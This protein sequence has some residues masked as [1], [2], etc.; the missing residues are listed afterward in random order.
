MRCENNH[1]TVNP[2]APRRDSFLMR[3]WV[4]SSSSEQDP[5]NIRCF[6]QPVSTGSGR[7]FSTLE[8]TI[9]YIRKHLTKA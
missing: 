8:E 4:E 1:T 3:V 2:R 7:Y 5:P 9:I 6:L